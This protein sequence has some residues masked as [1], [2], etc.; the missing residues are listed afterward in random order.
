L[1][2]VRPGKKSKTSRYSPY[3]KM[4]IDAGGDGTKTDSVAE[5]PKKKKKKKKSKAQKAKSQEK[6]EKNT[7]H[8]KSSAEKTSLM[9]A[10][11]PN[12]INAEPAVITVQK[13]KSAIEIVDSEDD[14]VMDDDFDS[15]EEAKEP[16]NQF[17]E[18]L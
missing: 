3:N 11:D 12:S 5:A 17:K 15:Q 13:S 18:T 4:D 6:R 9:Q 1:T 16:I 14:L 2:V 7:M 8:K 10:L